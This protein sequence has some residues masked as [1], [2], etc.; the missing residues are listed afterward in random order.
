MGFY[1][2]NNNKLCFSYAKKG[3][4]GIRLVDRC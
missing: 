4:E 3:K 1:K 2:Y